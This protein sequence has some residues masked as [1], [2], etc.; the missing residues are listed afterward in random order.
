[1]DANSRR[2]RLLRV[3]GFALPILLVSGAT[4]AC[5]APAEPAAADAAAELAADRQATA[6]ELARAAEAHDIC[7]GWAVKGSVPEAAGSNLG[8][9]VPVESSPEQCPNWV[10]VIAE[11][12]WTPESSESPDTAWVHLDGSSDLMF[13]LPGGDVMPQLGLTGDAVIDDPEF[14]VLRGALALP[15]LIA[16]AG[17]AQP[18]PR[19]TPSGTTTP[20]PDQLVPAGSDFWRDRGG[21]FVAGLVMLLLAGGGVWLGIR[22]RGREIREA[23]RRAAELV[24]QRNRKRRPTSKVKGGRPKSASAG[25][26]ASR[27]TAG[28]PDEQDDTAG[29]PDEQDDAADDGRRPAP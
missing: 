19:P 21:L 17:L 16:E 28:I 20:N 13:D 18:V 3:A 5:S 27:K 11:V 10:T 25:R 6:V 8:A 15:L 7:Y 22:L 14:E 4:A 9:T 12:T 24:R 26:D 23:E 29:T 1:M 2:R